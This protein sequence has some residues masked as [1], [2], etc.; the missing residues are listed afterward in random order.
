MSD[1]VG[2][3]VSFQRH[4]AAE[5]PRAILECLARAMSDDTPM[6]DI[7]DAA[8]AIG[9]GDVMGGLSLAELA[10]ALVTDAAPPE[11]AAAPAT[12]RRRRIPKAAP[13]S[14]QTAAR[15]TAR[16]VDPRAPA[17]AHD[18]LSHDQAI[19][20]LVPMVEE[21][22]QATML[23]LEART[24]MGRRKIRF[25]VG[26]LVKSGHLVRHGMG[27]GTHYTVAE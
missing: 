17:P 9:V 18:R 25:H 27:R 7:V 16:G 10:Q 5:R 6:G 13:R 20:L 11:P 2:F 26:Q 21:M 1:T 19:A 14:L 24:G 4:L 12:T 8:D 22:G 23:E 3:E 15:T